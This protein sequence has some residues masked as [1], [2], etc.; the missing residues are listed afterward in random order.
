VSSP[1][2]SVGEPAAPSRLALCCDYPEEQWVS[3]DLCAQMLF[4]Q[5]QSP[6]YSTLE[7]V[8]ICPPFKQRWQ[9][10][11]RLGK[12]PA[13]FNAD[14]L[15]NRLWDYPQQVKPL[16]GQFDYFH[17]CDHSYAAVVHSL[18]AERTGVYCHDIDAF[19]SLVT[20]EADPRPAWYQAMSRR[21]LTGL[22]K[23]AI[24]FYSTQDVRRQILEYGLIAPERLVQ[25]PLGISPEFTIQ[26][27]LPDL[28]YFQTCWHQR[29]KPPYLLHVGSCI[30]RK[31]V[32][33][34]LDVFAQLRQRYPALQLVKVSGTWTAAQQDQINRLQITDGIVHLHHLE[35]LQIAALYRQAALVLLP[36]E[37]EGFGLPVIEALA[38]GATVIASDIPVL[39]EVGGEAVVYCPVA[40]VDLWV[41]MVAKLLEQPELAP[42]KTSKQS[43]ATRF[44]WQTHAQII[45]QAYLN[46]PA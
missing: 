46:V 29:I 45:A 3:M 34:L 28:D 2:V 11:P 36:S 26:A 40:A 41:A 6:A 13:A 38:C 42:S 9:R 31:R 27:P 1:T 22:Q 33:V 25:A 19:R 17:V 15:C 37:A 35:R 20:P 21:I 5:L 23:A 44:S 18:P 7:A 39:R 30:P 14:R 10:L 16:R 8:K 43:Q 32:D 24:V 12:H 4:E